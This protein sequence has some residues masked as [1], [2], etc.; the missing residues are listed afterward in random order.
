[1]RGALQP[2]FVDASRA[3]Y[4][5]ALPHSAEANPAP[6]VD[7]VAVGPRGFDGEH[8]LTCGDEDSAHQITMVY[9]CSQSCFF[10]GESAD[11]CGSSGALT[12][13]I[14]LYETVLVRA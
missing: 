11:W 13:L 4:G 7:F 6:M 2:A 5:D 8:S 12:F 1:M 10:M 3:G 14:G 9:R